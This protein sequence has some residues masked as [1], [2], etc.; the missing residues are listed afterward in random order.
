MSLLLRCI[1]HGG[2]FLTIGKIYQAEYNQT[3]ENLPYIITNDKGFRHAIEDNLF[4]NIIDE[5]DSKLQNLL[6]E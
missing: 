6:R 4:I 3:P 2:Y 5:R 1:N